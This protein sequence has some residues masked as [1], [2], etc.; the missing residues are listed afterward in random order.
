MTEPTEIAVLG[1][2]TLFFLKEAFQLMKGRKHDKE[3]EELMWKSDLSGVAKDTK[4]L[5]ERLSDKGDKRAEVLTNIN[6]TVNGTHKKVNEMGAE[7]RIITQEL[8]K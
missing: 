8:L 3:I 7:V 4:A 6:H 1:L 5:L 2:V